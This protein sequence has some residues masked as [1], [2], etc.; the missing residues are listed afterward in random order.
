MLTGYFPALAFIDFFATSYKPVIVF[1]NVM[2]V[3]TALQGKM[4]LVNNT[5]Y[6]AL[7]L[8]NQMLVANLSSALMVALLAAVGY[9]WTHSILIIAYATL[10][11]MVFRVYASE[12]FLRHQMGEPFSFRPLSEGL[13][14]GFFLAITSALP[15]LIAFS[16]WLTFV[17]LLATS[18]RDQIV[19]HSVKIWR[20]RR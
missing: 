11:T 2:L 9:S 10:G 17:A 15:R 20:G 12:L 19:A 1:L 18:H 7:R 3:V 16:G 5:Y 6:K 8:E 14:L 13:V 4:Q